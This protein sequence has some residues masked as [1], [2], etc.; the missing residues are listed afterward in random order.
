LEATGAADANDLLHRFYT[1]EF[2]R[3][4]IASLSPLVT[5]AAENGDQIALDILKQA[6]AE[7]SWYV[8]GLYHHLF[9]NLEH[10][11][12][13]HVGG[14]FQ[15]VPLRVEFTSLI[16][17]RTP[18]QTGAPRY[19]PAAGAVLEA[20]RLDGNLSDLSDVPESDK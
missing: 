1:S 14:V 20:L 9:P 3:S 2:S 18:C 6:A 19:Y 11:F 13:S 7:L 5:R 15:S 10:A 17:L 12:V 16:H 8:E 4:K